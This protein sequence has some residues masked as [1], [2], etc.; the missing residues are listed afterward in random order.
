[1][2]FQDRNSALGA[3]DVLEEARAQAQPKQVKEET[4]N[5]RSHTH[6]TKKTQTPPRV[7]DQQS[8]N[9]QKEA[10]AIVDEAGVRS[11]YPQSARSS[12]LLH[13][14][15]RDL[16]ALQDLRR[17]SKDGEETASVLHRHRSDRGRDGEKASFVNEE[18][19]GAS[20]SST[21]STT[22]EENTQEQDFVIL[23][24]ERRAEDVHQQYADRLR[25]SLFFSQRQPPSHKNDSTIQTKSSFD[26]TKFRNRGYDKIKMRTRRNG[27]TRR[28]TGRDEAKTFDAADQR[29]ETEITRR[30][31]KWELMPL[32]DLDDLVNEFVNEM[33]SQ[34][35]IA[36]RKLRQRLTQTLLRAKAAE[37]QRRAALRRRNQSSS[38]ESQS[39][40]R[41]GRSEASSSSRSRLR[42]SKVDVTS[43]TDHTRNRKNQEQE[44][45]SSS[46]EDAHSRED[47]HATL[48]EGAQLLLE[49]GSF[50]IERA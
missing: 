46:D 26:T 22:G 5:A 19:T 35:Y 20:T 6:K 39:G 3:Q 43:R 34:R 28:E 27:R 40:N 29:M 7:E 13:W 24:P 23:F 2:L 38:F 41:N 8:R 45:E 4:S 21:T 36:G 31:T 47:E 32:K 50:D 14:L 33:V 17:R 10:E 37:E 9:S 48:L 1:M 42:G 49:E 25:D 30:A 44:R 11:V 15:N 12:R 18:T 16:R